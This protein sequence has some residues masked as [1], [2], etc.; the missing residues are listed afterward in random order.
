MHVLD[1]PHLFSFRSHPT[2]VLKE[3]KS[4]SSHW[5]EAEGITRT[6]LRPHGVKHD[7]FA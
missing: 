4:E 5:S 3:K 1:P 6:K 7:R 2:L